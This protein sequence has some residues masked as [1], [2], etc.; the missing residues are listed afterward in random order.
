M[1]EG[2]NWGKLVSKSTAQNIR[3]LQKCMRISETLSYCM[4]LFPVRTEEALD[5][6]TLFFPRLESLPQL[7]TDHQMTRQFTITVATALQHFLASLWSIFTHVGTWPIL[8]LPVDLKVDNVMVEVIN[9]KSVAFKVIDLDA[10]GILPLGDLKDVKSLTTFLCRFVPLNMVEESSPTNASMPLVLLNLFAATTGDP[11]TFFEALAAELLQS[12]NWH[13]DAIL[14][15]LGNMWQWL[16]LCFNLAMYTVKDIVDVACDKNVK[17]NM[18]DCDMFDFIVRLAC[19]QR[20][21][22]Y[23]DDSG[24]KFWT[25]LEGNATAIPIQDKTEFLLDLIYWTERNKL[26]YAWIFILELLRSLTGEDVQLPKTTKETVTRVCTSVCVLLES[27]YTL[28]DTETF[29]QQILSEYIHTPRG[30]WISQVWNCVIKSTENRVEHCVQLLE[31]ILVKLAG[32][33][34]KWMME[35]PIS[36]KLEA[37]TL[38]I[39]KYISE[40]FK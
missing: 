38:N 24:T 11:T 8:A 10:Y 34:C 16:P 4:F 21:I 9:S 29:F 13:A 1:S 7:I 17:L 5:K 14:Q 30:K 22:S 33:L 19:K 20:D 12:G 28:S 31:S 39:G 36:N 32:F 23:A 25:T 3:T 2:Q 6:V 37:A 27:V 15:L 40:N 35:H 26:G 18:C